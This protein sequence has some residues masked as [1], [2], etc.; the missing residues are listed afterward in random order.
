YSTSYRK[1]KDT[2]TWGERVRRQHE[3]WKDLMPS[4]IEAYLAWRYPSP[5]AQ[6][7]SPNPLASDDNP[8]D[9]EI[10]VVDIYD[11]LR[12]KT[13]PAPAERSVAEALVSAG[14]LCSTPIKPR[15]AISL[16]TL[17][18]LR[19]VRLFKPSFSIEAFAKLVCHY[20]CLP[21]RRTYRN[22]LSDAFDIY[23]A[24]LRAIDKRVLGAL[25]RDTPDWRVLNACPACCYKL[26][27]EPERPFS[28]MYCMDGNNSLKRM[29]PLG[30]RKIGDARVFEESDYFL[31][32]SFADRFANEV[33]SRPQQNSGAGMAS[34]DMMD[35]DDPPPLAPQSEGDPTDGAGGV[36]SL[37]TKNWK[38][39]QS[40]EK[41]R[42]WDIFE[43]TG[44][45]ASA[46]RHGLILWLVDMVRSGELARYPLA[47]VAKVLDVLGERMIGGYDVGCSFLSTV[48]H[49]SLGPRFAELHSRLCVNSFHGYSHD[50]SCQVN[51]HPTFIKGMG[52]E[53]L[54]TMER[55][56]S[57]SNQLASVIRYATAYRRRVLID[58]FFQQW[59]IEKYLNLGKMLF[60]NYHQALDI[61]KELEIVVTEG[62]KSLGVTAADLE[63]FA[64]EERAYLGLLG[65]ETPEDLHEIAYVETL[66]E[67]RS[68]ARTNRRFFAIDTTTGT[69]TAEIS[70]MPPQ[71]GPTD[72]D[73][74]TARTRKLET[75]TNKILTDRKYLENRKRE[76]T[77]QVAD[78]EVLLGVSTTWQPSD[79]AYIRVAKYIATRKYQQALS[80]L[81]RLIVQRLF[82]LHKLNLAQTGYRMRRNIAKNMQTRSRA[83]WNAIA[84]YNTAAAALDPPRPKVDWET[85]SHYQFLEE[86]DLLNETRADVRDK[87]WAQPAVR[88]LAR[89]SH[90][91]AGARDELVQVHIEARRVH[92]S[93]RDEDLHL[94][95]LLSRLMRQRDPIHGA[96][97]DYATRRR[98]ANAHVLMWLKKLYQLPQ[99]G[100]DPTP[101]TRISSP[102]VACIDHTDVGV[103]SIPQPLTEASEDEE[104]QTEMHVGDDDEDEDVQ[105][106]LTMLSEFIGNLTV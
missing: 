102:E 88:E 20:Y 75:A 46:C 90:R 9:I 51:F 89:V 69:A 37:C 57:S 17:E 19:C 61:I 93:I 85:V 99:F 53:D 24:I 98:A 38:A 66:Q 45:F 94:G 77:L 82:E 97:L 28:R 60:D 76:L 35:I 103:E 11:L 42:S 100:G 34:S 31:P 63:R 32:Q 40:D 87:P 52:I 14:Y 1:P 104:R 27:D 70:F 84:T 8:E 26:R 96:V 79:P 2:R 16:Q 49:S 65:K 41:K 59:D 21:Y 64:A 39:A 73:K 36:D 10:A 18:L 47:I 44:I 33:R 106:Q 62:M 81:Q 80:N 55:I 105:D 6:T 71:S 23:L 3:H 30:G 78:F 83:I 86:F 5:S 25:G 92:T 7:S 101:G 68:L 15:L 56:F 95:L 50:Y 29:R 12:T 13:I 58:L 91:L 48:Q 43:E 4:I 67:Y 54:E 74:E 22:A 72:Y